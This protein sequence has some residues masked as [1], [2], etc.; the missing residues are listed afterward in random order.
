M[1][2]ARISGIPLAVIESRSGMRRGREGREGCEGRGGR[3]PQVMLRYLD[4][5]GVETSVPGLHRRVN[6]QQIDFCHRITFN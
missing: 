3:G 6:R 1:A 5:P 2:P 4:G